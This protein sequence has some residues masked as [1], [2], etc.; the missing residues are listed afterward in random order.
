M[1]KIVDSLKGIIK[2]SI[3]AFIGILV[4][5]PYLQKAE[6]MPDMSVIG[7]LKLIHKNKLEKLCVE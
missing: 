5:S 6:L 2:I 7:I 4:L 3:I 1:Q